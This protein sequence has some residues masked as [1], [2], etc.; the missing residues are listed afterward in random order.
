MPS[1]PEDILDELSTIIMDLGAIREKVTDATDR[2]AINNQIKALTK[3][4]RTIDDERASQSNDEIESAKNSLEQITNDLKIEKQ[5]ADQRRNRDSS[6]CSSHCYCRKNRK[7]HCHSCLSPP[8][9]ATRFREEAKNEPITGC[10]G[11]GLLKFTCHRL[12]EY[13]TVGSLMK[14]S[15]F[16]SFGANH[17]GIT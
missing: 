2:S 9:L 10:A 17:H 13:G 7:I 3:W 16:P 1:T 14:Y 11:E 5:E 12:L 8:R 15:V 6:S 4:W